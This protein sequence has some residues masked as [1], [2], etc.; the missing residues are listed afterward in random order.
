VKEYE[1]VDGCPVLDEYE[2]TGMDREGQE[3]P[4]KPKPY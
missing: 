4:L 3:L 2:H 1:V